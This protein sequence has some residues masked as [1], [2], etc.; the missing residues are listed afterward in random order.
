MLTHRGAW[1]HFFISVRRFRWI[2]LCR[3]NVAAVWEP[4]LLMHLEK[5][6][7]APMAKPHGVYAVNGKQVWYGVA[8]IWSK[9]ES[10][11]V[12]LRVRDGTLIQKSIENNNDC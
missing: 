11:I 4:S 9:H 1:Y 5:I 12:L 6:N 3:N 10:K 8:L 7:I 2:Y